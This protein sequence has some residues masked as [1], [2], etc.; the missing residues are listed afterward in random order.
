[1][2]VTFVVLAI[3]TAFFAFLTPLFHLVDG[4]GAAQFDGTARLV[5]FFDGFIITAFCVFIALAALMGFA[6]GS[7]RMA[8]VFGILWQTE[9]PTRGEWWMAVSI[10][11][12]LF[13]TMVVYA[14]R[15]LGFI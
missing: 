7:E 12:A 3:T 15:K 14:L 1:M 13:G 10:V 6:L 4:H 9:T 11:V 8:R 2:A 5:L